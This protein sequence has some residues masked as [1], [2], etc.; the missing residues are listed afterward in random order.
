MRAPQPYIAG[1]TRI[2]TGKHIADLTPIRVQ[3]TNKIYPFDKLNETIYRDDASPIHLRDYNHNKCVRPRC[4][5][6][7]QYIWIAA[8]KLSGG[9]CIYNGGILEINVDYAVIAMGFCMPCA[10]KRQFV[11]HMLY[12]NGTRTVKSYT[13][14]APTIPIPLPEPAIHT[15]LS[16]TYNVVCIDHDHKNLYVFTTDGTYNA[17]CI[18]TGKHV[19][20]TD[21]RLSSVNKYK[22][23]ITKSNDVEMIGLYGANGA[24][25]SSEYPGCTHLYPT[26]CD[27]LIA[28]S[29][30]NIPEWNPR[31]RIISLKAVP[32]S[33]V[34]RTHIYRGY[35]IVSGENYCGVTYYQYSWSWDI[36]AFQSRDVKDRVLFYIM[37][38]K[39][40]GIMDDLIKIIIKFVMNP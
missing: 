14:I 18:N 32:Y 25:P 22:V 17:Y 3:G 2:P 33:D 15:I 6:I 27:V 19:E 10:T 8:I 1:I 31:R 20:M 7:G 9:I 34:I 29:G 35:S 38:L 16:F 39:R 37:I 30:A 26:D 23:I 4:I 36:A 24:A 11:W 13:P 21:Y 28:K 5:V 12:N 40:L